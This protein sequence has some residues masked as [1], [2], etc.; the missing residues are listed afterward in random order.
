MR[1]CPRMIF[2]WM[3]AA[4]P[5]AQAAPPVETS[6]TAR[7]APAGLAARVWEITD[8]VLDHH[9]DPP[10]RQEMIVVS[11][12]RVYNAA[13][14]PIP[15][16]LA[17]RVSA[18]SGPEELAPVLDEA[19]SRLPA[20]K[21]EVANEE[22]EPDDF[23]IDSLLDALPEGASLITA[24]AIEVQDQFAGNRYV[25]LHIALGMNRESRRMSVAQVFKGG[26]A[27]KAGVK[28]GDV[29][30]EI[31]G[32]STEG[33]PLPKVV[34]RL[35]GPEG[36][37]VVIR[38]RQPKAAEARVFTITR[39]VLPRSTV[40][41]IRDRTDGGEDVLISSNEPIGY[42]KFEEILG[43][44]PHELR[45]LARQLEE[46]G[47]KALV[48]DLRPVRQAHFH[49][50]VLLADS[51]LDGGTIG[52]MR[53]ARGV[54]TFRAEPDS[55]F[56]GWPLALLVDNDTPPTAQW[57]AAAAPGQPPGDH[58]RDARTQGPGARGSPARAG[59]RAEHRGGRAI[60]RPDRRGLDVDRDGDRP[61]G[62]RRWPPTRRTQG[63]FSGQ[64]RARH[65]PRGNAGRGRPH[66][67]RRGAAASSAP[68][69]ALSANL[70]VR[71]LRRCRHGSL[72]SAVHR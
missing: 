17:R 72:D 1:R 69:I 68:E 35:R 30:E 39:G 26:P 43:S 9:I 23:L 3:I 12:K 14:L 8:L 55:L 29:I 34:E 31:D 13:G 49:P 56:P 66:P 15:A 37:Q 44:T 40:K 61:A 50:T 42:L 52:R 65:H 24:Q 57:L 67:G 53:T 16:G 21:I 51:L 62:A 33:I 63:R 19:W 11:L 71:N 20:D 28:D 18:I 48:V 22:M 46:E 32:T 10:M 36:S 6:S 7:K 58:R 45:K 60:V 41:G 38:V 64:L 47:A 5:A 59:P 25:G 4:Y 70:F 2:A 27:D 54:E